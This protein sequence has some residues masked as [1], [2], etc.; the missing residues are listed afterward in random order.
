LTLRPRYIAPLGLRR[1]VEAGGPGLDQRGVQEGGEVLVGRLQLGPRGL[2]AG[3]TRRF[4]R[5]GMTAIWAESE[6]GERAPPEAIR[7]RLWR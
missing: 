6:E 5:A 4:L 2:G 7:A 1:L 3:Q